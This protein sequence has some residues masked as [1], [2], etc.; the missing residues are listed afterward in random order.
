MTTIGVV[1]RGER[2]SAFVRNLTA[3][4]YRVAVADRAGA[5]DMVKALSAPRAV[6][7]LASPGLD[8][9]LAELLPRLEPGDVLADGDASRFSDTGRRTAWLRGSGV[10]FA[11]CA[12][13]GRPR[14]IERGPSYV[15]G[16]D[17]AA[18]RRLLPLLTATA[19]RFQNVPCV[20]YAGA[21]SA[22][23]FAGQVHEELATAEA[24]LAAEAYALL[25]DRAVLRAWQAGE[26]ITE[27]A[28][29]KDRP[30]PVRPL[31]VTVAEIRAAWYAARAVAYARAV[32]RLRAAG[33]AYG[34]GMDLAA[35]TSAWRGGTAL[36]G[37][38]LTYAREALTAMPDEGLLD[39]PYFALTLRETRPAWRRV[40][41]AAGRAGIPVP[42]LAT[43]AEPPVT[44]SSFDAHPRL[45]R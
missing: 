35:V 37:R 11:G 41:C 9:L 20:A 45:L 25:G 43:A 3:R 13:A 39:D 12:I 24:E 30:G 5:A 26:M 22:G 42:A 19:A 8:G 2:G 6:I 1:T 23:H 10:L 15:V 34:W 7:L 18:H 16:G 28:V 38:L 29:P 14:T 31:T 32:E 36:A 33:A 40:V 21:G 44:A 17:R 27:P 4:G